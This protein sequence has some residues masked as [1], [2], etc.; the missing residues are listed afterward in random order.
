ML[1]LESLLAVA[2]YHDNAEEAANDR[3]A[4]EEKND[5][6]SDSPD[7]WREEVL[8][9][10]GVVD[11]WLFSCIRLDMCKASK[12]SLYHQKCPDCVVEKDG[13]SEDEHCKAD[14]TIK[15]Q[16]GQHEQSCFQSSTSTYKSIGG[17]NGF[18]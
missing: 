3:A 12:Q 15:L 8:G 4:K 9:R 5:W 11:K 16:R 1:G 6:N 2:P 10:V 18:V 13:R 17:H 7:A 14:E